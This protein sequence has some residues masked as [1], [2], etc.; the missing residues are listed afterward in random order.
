MCVLVVLL[1]WGTPAP[2]HTSTHLHTHIY[3]HAYTY[4]QDGCVK[5]AM[6]CIEELTGLDLDG[7][8]KTMNRCC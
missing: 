2:T 3:T 1:V 4:T 7:D 6:D 8:G 5:R